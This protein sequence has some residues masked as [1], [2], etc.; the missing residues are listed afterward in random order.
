M[1]IRRGAA[2]GATGAVLA[3]L[4]AGCSQSLDEATAEY[5]NDLDA[6][7]AEAAQF[8]ELVAG[9][10]TVAEITA[11]ARAVSDAYQEVRAAG[12]DVGQAISEQVDDAY[13]A[14]QDQVDQI[15]ADTSLSDAVPQYGDA[16][17]GYLDQLAE[18]S[19]DVGCE[20]A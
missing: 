9:N 17:E 3:L 20:D 13:S 6:L 4:V 12:Q 8:Q 15:P 5:C 14:Y 11:Q 10:A 19:N 16:V 1:R 2:A 7:R 18:I